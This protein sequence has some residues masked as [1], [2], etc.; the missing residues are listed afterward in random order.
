MT[1][2]VKPIRYSLEDLRS[3]KKLTLTHLKGF[4]KKDP[5]NLWISHRTAFNGMID[6][7]DTCDDQSFKPAVFNDEKVVQSV[8][9]EELTVVGDS[10]D[11]ITIYED[12]D[13]YGLSVYNCCGESVVAYPKHPVTE[14]NPYG[15][16][17]HEQEINPTVI[18]TLAETEIEG[19]KLK[20]FQTRF[21]GEMG[22]VAN[23]VFPADC[24]V[25]RLE[26]ERRKA[27]GAHVFYYGRKVCK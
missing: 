5:K 25:E 1:A 15:K 11:H 6:C 12:D 14:E 17:L 4:L 24:S 8:G 19:K 21:I 9:V 3:K 2:S 13:F 26:E 27:V 18:A 7:V 22:A 16:T 23:D 20:Y 10:R